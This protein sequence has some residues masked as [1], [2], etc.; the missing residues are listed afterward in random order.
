MQGVIHT[1]SAKQGNGCKFLDLLNIESPNILLYN[2]TNAFKLKE[3]QYLVF[4]SPESQ[5]AHKFYL[6]IQASVGNAF[7]SLFE[8]FIGGEHEILIKKQQG[9]NEIQYIIASS[10]ANLLLC[11]KK[12]QKWQKYMKYPSSYIALLRN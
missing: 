7:F 6:V 1:Y 12:I 3:N 8:N 9:Q 10:H 2:P 11:K 5:A 4:T